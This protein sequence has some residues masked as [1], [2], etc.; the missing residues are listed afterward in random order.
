MS[1]IV[2]ILEQP[3]ISSPPSATSLRGFQR[4]LSEVKEKGEIP[5]ELS[6]R[7]I[8]ENLAHLTSLQR[9][10]LICPNY[11]RKEVRYLLND[12]SPYQVALSLK[13]NS[14]LSHGTAVF[15]HSLNEERPHR[16]YLNHE[17]SL[18][19]SR[20]KREELSQEGIARAF[21]NNQ[22]E[23]KLVF[24]FRDYEIVVLSGKHTGR[25]EVGPLLDSNGIELDVTS[26]ER[27]LIDIAVRP[28]YSGGVEKVREAYQGARQ[29]CSV[30]VLLG[31]LRKLD[32]VYPYHQVIGFYMERA[33]WDEKLTSR[34]LALGVE[35]D[36]YLTYGMKE[37]EFDSRWRVFYPKGF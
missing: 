31:T 21:A 6:F 5:K 4:I 3:L 35:H 17:Q 24:N 7:E 34:V 9:I 12:P 36:F 32:Y 28:T 13:G 10:E 11:D 15:L 27:T 1:D 8:R 37:T 19:P 14:Y 22:R 16:I 33:G 18:K 23:S 20:G 25:L 29:R 2:K 26:I 30:N